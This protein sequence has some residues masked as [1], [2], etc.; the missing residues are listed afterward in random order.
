MTMYFQVVNTGDA[1]V[2]TNI[3]MDPSLLDPAAGIMDV[4]T[5]S[6]KP[7]KNGGRYTLRPIDPADLKTVMMRIQETYNDMQRATLLGTFGAYESLRTAVGGLF[8]TMTFVQI[9]SAT[10]MAILLNPMDDTKLPLV[11]VDIYEVLTQTLDKY[12]A[13]TLTA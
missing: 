8:Q 12:H 6:M 2:I 10:D 1:T 4:E 11:K 5:Q 9:T 3:C 7:I 13:A